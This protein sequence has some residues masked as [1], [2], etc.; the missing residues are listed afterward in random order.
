MFSRVQKGWTATAESTGVVD[1]YGEEDEL[2]DVQG[3]SLGEL[4]R[5]RLQMD[6]RGTPAGAQQESD[7]EARGWAGH[8]GEGDS[9][10]DRGPLKWPQ[11]MGPELEEIL[12]D[13]LVTACMTFPVETGL[14]VFR[15]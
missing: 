10:V 6:Q 8:W 7:D 9:T 2:E 13:E 3:V 11:D 12:V 14:D 4:N 15:Q 5:V 1:D